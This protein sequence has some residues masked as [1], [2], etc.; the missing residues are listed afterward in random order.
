ME[1]LEW[2]QDGY[3]LLEPIQSASSFTS[4]H[5]KYERKALAKDDKGRTV[6]FDDSDSVDFTIGTK[7][8]SIVPITKILAILKEEDNGQ[9]NS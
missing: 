2:I 6:V 1:H 7:N 5:H 3:K 9:T 8:Y 4:E